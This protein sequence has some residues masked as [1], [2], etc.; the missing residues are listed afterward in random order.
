MSSA[1]D[2][3]GYIRQ[4]LYSIDFHLSRGN[5]SFSNNY[6]VIRVMKVIPKRCS[7]AE[8]RR[9]EITSRCL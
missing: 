9:G 6:D 7:R 1:A 3:V 5:K 4:I 2:V 8:G